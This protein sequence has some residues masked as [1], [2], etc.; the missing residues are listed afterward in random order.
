MYFHSSAGSREE[1]VLLML[2]VL[3]NFNSR[4]KTENAKE[5]WKTAKRKKGFFVDDDGGR[6]EESGGGG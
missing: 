2:K 4:R 5:L 3:N 6:R 1:G